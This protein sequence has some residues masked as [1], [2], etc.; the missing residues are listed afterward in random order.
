MAQ[1]SALGKTLKTYANQHGSWPYSDAGSDAAAYLLH[2][3]VPAATFDVPHAPGSDGSA[4]YDHDH[5]QLVGSGYLYLNPPPKQLR[6]T[7]SK[8]LCLAVERQPDDSNGV[9]ALFSDGSVLYVPL[10]GNMT[11]ADLLGK[12]DSAARSFTGQRS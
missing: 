4:A 7:S 5:Q 2:E 3:A 8:V 9:Y 12:D 11:P 10:S 1:L 6:P